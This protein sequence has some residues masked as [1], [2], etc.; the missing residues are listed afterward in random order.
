VD[1][2]GTSSHLPRL[3]PADPQTRRAESV[4]PAVRAPRAPRPVRGRPHRCQNW[5]RHHTGHPPSRCPAPP[6]RD[7]PPRGVTGAT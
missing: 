7:A 4:L 5:R 6:R 3:R 2:R 1:E